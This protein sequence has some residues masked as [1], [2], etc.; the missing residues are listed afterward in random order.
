M[1]TTIDLAKELT[2]PTPLEPS[3]SEVEAQRRVTGFDV[4]HVRKL[5]LDKATAEAKKINAIDPDGWSE[6]AEAQKAADEA[7]ARA[8][9]VRNER[10]G[11]ITS[12]ERMLIARAKLLIVIGHVQGLRDDT[13]KLEV[14]ATA[15]LDAYIDNLTNPSPANQT[16]WADGFQNLAGLAALKPFI[17]KRLQALEKQA[18]DLTQEIQEKAKAEKLDLKNLLAR[19]RGDASAISDRGQQNDVVL[20][21]MFEGDWM[22]IPEPK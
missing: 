5:L 8:E 12:L 16:R 7:T 4:D 14:I 21:S 18:A 22:D 10:R 1:R 17:P 19:M 3:A 20:H 13:L 2:E 11:V 6:I 9:R 15:T